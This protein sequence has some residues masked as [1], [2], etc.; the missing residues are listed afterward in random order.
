MS[1]S[2]PW[3]SYLLPHSSFT[4]SRSAA[5][6]FFLDLQERRAREAQMRMGGGE[7]KAEWGTHMWIWRDHDGTAG[8]AHVDEVGPY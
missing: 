4:S 6:A 1:R 7:D 5:T 2:T 3:M 8:A